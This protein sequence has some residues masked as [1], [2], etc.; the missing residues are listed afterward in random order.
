MRDAAALASFV[1]YS[2]EPFTYSK[3]P[4]SQSKGP[5]VHSKEQRGAAALASLVTMV[6]LHSKDLYL[7]SKELYVKADRNS[8]MSLVSRKIT[9]FDASVYRGLEHDN[10]AKCTQAQIHDDNVA[11]S[12]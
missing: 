1:T 4:C 5:Y 12:A 7:H 11:Q 10:V 2:Q 8:P 3:E 9:G 6:P